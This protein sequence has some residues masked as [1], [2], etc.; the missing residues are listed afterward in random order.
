MQPCY[1]LYQVFNLVLYIII[2]LSFDLLAFPSALKIMWIPGQLC[3]QT[4]K[5]LTV[6]KSLT[7]LTV[8]MLSSISG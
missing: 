7:Y 3:P 4:W 6:H 1:H 5:S 8:F 2:R